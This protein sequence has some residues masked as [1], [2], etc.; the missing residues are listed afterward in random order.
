MTDSQKHLIWRLGLIILLLAAVYGNTLNHGFVWDDT[1]IIVNNPLLE[2]LSNIPKFFIS[3]DT[4]EES[5]GY[6]RPATY[7]SFALD[8]AIWGVN[9]VGFHI[10]NLVLHMV[11]VLLF[12]AVISAMF[13]KERLAFVAALVFALHPLAGETVNFLAGGRNTLLSACF[14]LLSLLCYIKKKPVVAAASFI[15]A[16]FS[17][18]F[19]LLLPM[20]FYIYD[21]RIQ[22]EKIR[23][24]GYIPYL[25]SVACYLTLRSFAV[26]KA[27][28][29][30]SINPSDIVTAPYMVVRYALNMIF[31]L[32]LKVLYDVQPGIMICIVCS[33]V[34][35]FM[36][37][38]V[39]IFRKHDEILMSATWFL[40]FLL[41][42]INIIPLRTTTVMADRYAYFSLMG[43][44]LCLA[45]VICR[46]NGRVATA[47][48]VTL[49][50][51]FA[52]VDF[53]RNSVWKNE[54][55]LFT[56]MTK[57]APE[58]FAGFKNLGLAY[59]RNGEITRA[60]HYLESAD[61]KPDIPAKFLTGD[62]YIFWKENM[63]DLAEKSLLRVL[64]MEPLNPEPNLV[65]MMINEQKGDKLLAQSYRDKVKGMGYGID[66]VLFNRTIDLCRA[67]ETYIS[68]RQYIE[69]AIYL[70]QALK[71]NPEYIPALIDMGSMRAEQGDYADAIRYLN[72][73]VAIDPLNA[74][75]HNN[76]ATVYRLQGRFA[77]AQQEMIKFREA[78]SVA[79]QKGI[80]AGH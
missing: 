75:A 57:D 58:K 31:P 71:I 77:A 1:Y 47:A 80:G 60:V 70:W 59:Y 8:R 5:T 39:Y 24:S 19:A 29:L 34:L 12:Y 13:K 49:C 74:P 23:V 16:I 78:D 30:S 61:S 14:A 35:V 42:V 4:I 66:E 17:K 21:C 7:I 43:F 38:A 20:I 25:I 52:F 33:I 76:L 6:Y 48:A 54:I 44:A 28:F 73:A 10:T 41:P 65:L 36:T 3:E 9:P 63:P 32:Q 37:G 11:A 55:A 2:K 51:V 27:N 46:G 68:K 22:R 26:Q 79:K 72:K 62:A 67:G 18:E 56:R 64:E 40:L 69:A 15:I 50:T 45:T 53:N